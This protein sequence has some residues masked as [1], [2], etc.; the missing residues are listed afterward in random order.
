MEEN[1]WLESEPLDTGVGHQ[2]RITRKGERLYQAV[3]PAWREAQNQIEELLGTSGTNA[4]RR[5]VDQVRESG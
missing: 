5:A 4:V 2:L 1:G 3:A